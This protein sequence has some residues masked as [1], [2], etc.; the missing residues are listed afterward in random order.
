MTPINQRRVT[1]FKANRRGYVSLWLFLV[2]FIL[3][4]GSEFIANDRPLFISHD[5]SWYVPAINTYAE[6]QF[7]GE[8]ETAADY[9]D[10]FVI[11][12]IEEKGWILWPPVRYSF[13]TIIQDLPS[14]AP[15]PPKRK[16]LARHR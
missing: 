7:G 11:E 6:T 3:S 2:L 13:D 1:N 14:P 15:S 9:R 12:L 8:F 16:K 5:G 10:P 4:L